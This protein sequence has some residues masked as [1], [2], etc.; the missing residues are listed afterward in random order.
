MACFTRANGKI[1]G[2]SALLCFGKIYI[3]LRNL[4]LKQ[5]GSTRTQHVRRII[6]SV[7]EL[8]KQ[9][10]RS[11]LNAMSTKESTE[12]C[13][14][15]PVKT[16]FNV[17][18]KTDEPAT[19]D[20][21]KRRRKSAK[22]RPGERYV[23]PPQK[24]NPGVSFSQEHFAETSYYFEVGLRKVYPYYYDFKTYCKGRWIGKSLLEVFKSEFRSESIDYYY[25]AVKAGRIRL[26][27]TP[28]DD[29]NITL[30]VRSHMT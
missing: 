24:R 18:R 23:P 29:L 4:N 5:H 15:D 26:N 17:K 8:K 20:S 1:A 13:S 21:A 7:K 6:T 30:K 16:H 2:F 27:E 14:V 9:R 19:Q 12:N 28:V 11:E 3:S 25:K 22:K 10:R